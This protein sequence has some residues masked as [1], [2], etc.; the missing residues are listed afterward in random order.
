MRRPRIKPAHR[1]V[2]YGEDRIGIGGIISGIFTEVVDRDGWVWTLLTML[3]GS[4]TVDQ[5]VAELISRHPGRSEGEVR[6]ALG[7][8]YRAGYLEDADESV[9]P[10]LTAADQERYGRGRA[11]FSWMDRL[12]RETSWDSQLLLRQARVAVIG[13][14]GAGGNAA[15]ALTASGVGHVHCV[16]PDVVE[17]S[18]LNRQML[19]SERDLGRPKVTA[20]VDRLRTHNSTVEVTGERRNIDG[21]CSLLT[22]AAGFDVLV[23]TADRPA[24][25]LS[26]AN[27]VC[28]STGTAW[29]HGGY[30]GPQ[31]AIGLYRPGTGP[32]YD[33]ASTTERNRLA[34]LPPRTGWAGN[35]TTA[36]MHAANAVSAGIAGL[37]TAHAAM[38]LITGV[39]AL[40]TNCQF[41]LNLVTLW[42]SFVIEPDS[43]VPGCPTCGRPGS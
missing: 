19:F 27:Q 25:I 7:D 42:E 18:N 15:L 10:G 41:G 36:Q 26:W 29:V 37:F 3:D 9:P 17:L 32:C 21:P 1:P 39:P 30:H 13:V 6:G 5:T 35:D 43:P 4:L 38:S 8:L 22:L 24:E 28:H 33:C 2:R 16:D 20:A 40:R 11:L 31:V 23:V 12:P 34:G 14:G